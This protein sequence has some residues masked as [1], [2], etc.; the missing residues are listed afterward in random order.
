MKNQLDDKKF[1]SIKYERSANGSA[2]MRTLK[3]RIDAYFEESKLSKYGNSE[4]YIKASMILFVFFTSYTLMLSDRYPSWTNLFLGTICGLC[5]VMMVMNIGHDAAHNSLFKNKK[6][7]AI[8]C[9]S[10]E[11]AGLSQYLWKLNHN[12]IHHP[13][14]NVSP[15]DGE[16]NESMPFIRMSPFF[17]KSWFQRYQHYYA[18]L[19]Y[20]F[21]TI[22]LTLVRDFQDMHILPRQYRQQV[23]RHFPIRRYVLF[24][25]SKFFYIFYGLILPMIV[26]SAAWWKV[27]LGYFFVHAVMSI[28]ELCIQLPLHVNE[29]SKVIEA[30][31]DG[32]ILKK[33]EQHILEN[34]TDYWPDSRVANFITGG[35][36]THTIHHFFPGINHIHYIALTKILADTSKEFGMVYQCSPIMQ[37]LK[38]HYKRIKQLAIEP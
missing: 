6:L 30:L 17:K 15:V 4:V 24:I 25:V 2:F 29:N 5:T 35:I 20:L 11:L 23:I 8:S 10:F 32:L 18:P 34:T 36:N 33:R 22:N 27:L 9:Y 19:L 1:L 12:I 21:F 37:G 3:S 38:S 13:Y 28:F 16:I 26:L 31:D 7:N 14:P